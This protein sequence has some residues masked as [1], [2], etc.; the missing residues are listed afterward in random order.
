MRK[1]AQKPF[2]PLNL[3]FFAEASEGG[4]NEPI[5]GN[6]LSLDE[7]MDKFTAED[8]LNHPNMAKAIQSRVDTT[9]TKALGTARKR[10]EQ[11]QS[12]AQKLENMSAEQ[13]R[14]FDLDQREKKLLERE[15]ADERRQ[16][17]LSAGNELQRRGLDARFKEYLTGKDAEET[18]ER[19]NTFEAAFKEAVKNATNERMRGE[20]P[21]KDVNGGS[22]FTLEEIKG[23]STAEINANWDAIQEVLRTSK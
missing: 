11:E 19:I 1:E 18:S 12:E 6:E 20:K 15:K 13:R 8:I 2:F 7:V 23:M 17:E 3:Q 22:K 4:E 5:D 21:P 10:W 14:A 9:V 16:L